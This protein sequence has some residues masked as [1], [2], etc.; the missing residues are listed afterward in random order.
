MEAVRAAFFHRC[1]WIFPRETRLCFNIFFLCNVE[2]SS[3]YE[4]FIL[5]ER[6]NV[7]DE[8]LNGQ[9]K[10]DQRGHFPLVLEYYKTYIEVDGEE[11]GLNISGLDIDANQLL[12]SHKFADC[13]AIVI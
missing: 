4:E 6:F 1:P 9:R 3:L 12:I 13:D 8:R 11:Y 5:D 7:I 10:I 2:S